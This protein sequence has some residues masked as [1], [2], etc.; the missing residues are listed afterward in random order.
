MEGA[1]PCCKHFLPIALLL[2]PLV[3]GASPQQQYDR[4]TTGAGTDATAIAGFTRTVHAY[5]NLHRTVA[6]WLSPEEMCADPEEIQR[7]IERLA[8]A[9][10]TEK[11]AARTGDLR[12]DC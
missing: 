4:P 10:R 2:T 9:L 11:A 1:K 3:A 7:R 12:G 6:A 5:A 8:E